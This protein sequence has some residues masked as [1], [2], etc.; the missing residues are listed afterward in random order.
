MNQP[1]VS[2]I[3]PTY[4]RANTISRAI[5][6]VLNQTYSNL[7]LIVIDDG[8][9]D[10][11]GDIMN[12]YLKEDPRISYVKQ[13]HLGANYARNYGIK[14]AKGQYIAFQ[15]SDDEWFN[16]KLEKLLNVAQ[17]SNEGYAGVFTAFYR[18]DQDGN[19]QLIPKDR[20]ERLS[21][22]EQFKLLL[23]N[24]FIGTPSM[25]LKKE[26]IIDVEGFSN[27]LPRFQDWEFCLRIGLKY[28]LYYSP[29]PL[30]ISYDSSNSISR[31]KE[32][33]VTALEFILSNFYEV[34]KKDTKV[35]SHHYY[36][37]GSSYFVLGDKIKARD[38]FL[39]TIQNNSLYIKAWIKLIWTFFVKGE[40]I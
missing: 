35:L 8:S 7:E 29:E 15:D 19:K 16:H 33:G 18:C 38:N 36:R 30:F 1:L 13:E 5:D 17:L 32:A 2:V 37:L 28:R 39:K 9:T 34:L 26:A 40:K 12:E 27:N 3:L 14:L 10:N 25:I 31:N 20:I 22:E 21:W 11:T 23:V 24:N 6:S 4:N